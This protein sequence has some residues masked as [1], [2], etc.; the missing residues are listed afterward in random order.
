MDTLCAACKQ[1][2]TTDRVIKCSTCDANYHK[3]CVN[4]TLIDTNKLS[5]NWQCPNCRAKTPRTDNSNTPVRSS[6]CTEL[7]ASNVNTQSR[8]CKRMAVGS[9]ARDT[10]ENL[11]SFADLVSEIRLMR[12]D[13]DEVKVSLKS[14]LEGVQQCNA[15]LDNY[16]ERIKSL[17]HG[18]SQLVTLNETICNLKETLNHQL[19]SVMRNEIEIIGIEESSSENLNH[20]VL[21]TAAKLGVQLTMDDI[22]WT[23]RA[24]LKKTPIPDSNAKFPR[25]VIVRLLRR[26]KRD[27]L[28]KASK[29]RRN[30]SSKDIDIDG[31]MR[32]IFVNEHLTK[33]NRILFREARARAQRTGHK[34]CWTKNGRI[35]VRKTEGQPAITIKNIKELDLFLGIHVEAKSFSD[36]PN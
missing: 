25:P 30:L 12:T 11:V 14:L 10:T 9:P 28:I 17:E 36:T 19:Q 16:E 34:Y 27:E 20:T 7:D 18:N 21:L 1:D 13:M 8:G 3:I 23:V 22:D 31:P 15:R 32:K 5:D 33:E 6:T 35:L 4:A 29:T 26:S 24:G 2:I